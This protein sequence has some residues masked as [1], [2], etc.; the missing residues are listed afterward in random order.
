[1]HGLGELWTPRRLLTV[2][3][4]VVL[5]LVAAL[6]GQSVS[7][8]VEP[9]TASTADPAVSRDLAATPR[10]PLADPAPGLDAPTADAGEDQR[11]DEGSTVTLDGSGSQADMRPGLVPS[12]RQGSLTDGTVLTSEL[13]G[14]NGSSM[15]AGRVGLET[16]PTQRGVGLVYIIDVSGSAAWDGGCTGDT[17]NDGID[18]SVL[19][20]EIQAIIALNR[21]LAAGSKVKSVSVVTYSDGA[22]SVN[23]RPGPGTRLLRVPPSNDLDSDDVLDVEEALVKTSCQRCHQLHGRCSVGLSGCR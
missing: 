11:V 7:V 21:R 2:V 23:L 19:D 4:T 17:N 15:V 20:C 16:A 6:V 14:E 5:S 12:R 8:A 18:G 9:L 3:A 1:M 10:L 22:G 13:V